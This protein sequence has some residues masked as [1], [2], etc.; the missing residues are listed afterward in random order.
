MAA[1]NDYKNYV[2]I[3]DPEIGKDVD[4][5]EAVS[6]IIGTMV[7]RRCALGISRQDLAKMSGISCTSIARME[8]G[9]VSPRLSTILSLLP[10]LDLELAL[11]T[12]DAL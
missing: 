4:E 9:L 1:W 7:V 10:H 3:S 6:R 5:A 8:S 12:S 11:E 2:R